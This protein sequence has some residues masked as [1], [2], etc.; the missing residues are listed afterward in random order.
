M[1]RHW[2]EQ[3]AK[4]YLESQGHRI[5]AQNY[6]IRGAELD[7]ITECSASVLEHPIAAQQGVLVFVEVKQRRRLD[8]GHPAEMI[9]AAKI[10]RLRQAA[11]H[12]VLE[13]YGRDDLAMRF[14]AVLLIG[15]RHD[16]RLEHL[17]NI[18]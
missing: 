12:Y 15:S 2:S 3:C 13:H 6:C 9:T 8:Y 17:Q 10:A 16:Y 14:D 4:E 1:P 7:L 11:W 5:L 18:C